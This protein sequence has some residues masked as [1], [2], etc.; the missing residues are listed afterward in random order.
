MELETRLQNITDTVIANQNALIA[1]AD[2]IARQPQI[3]PGLLKSNLEVAIATDF[4]DFHPAT[5]ALL[6]KLLAIVVR[7]NPGL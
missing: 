6:E 7:A 2:I 3:D 5:A 1:L 4:A